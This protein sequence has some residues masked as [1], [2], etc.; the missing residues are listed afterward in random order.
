MQG[1]LLRLFD[2]FMQHEQRLLR[3]MTFL[4]ITFWTVVFLNLL[5]AIHVSGSGALIHYILITGFVL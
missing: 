4:K 3:Q 2:S 5:L 1:L